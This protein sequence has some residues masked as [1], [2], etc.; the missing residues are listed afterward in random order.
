MLLEEYD[1]FAADDDDIGNVDTVKIRI[2][3]KDDIPC[4]STYHSIPRP[5]HQELKH[6]IED[7]LNRKWI[8][9]SHSEYSSSVVAVEKKDG[10]LRLCCD[11]RKLSAKTVPDR[12]PLHFI[13][14]II[15]SLGTNHYFS[16]LD[17]QHITSY[18]EKQKRR[19]R[20][21][22][23]TP[24]SF[25]SGSG[26]NL[27]LRMLQPAFSAS[28]SPVWES[29]EMILLYHIWMTCWSFQRVFM[30]T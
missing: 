2:K 8:T 7:L 21:A 27:A 23:L 28:W 3:V 4:Q 19:K 24:W 30:I 15:V 26:S 12:H 14:D 18:K 9:S 20:T 25:M 5:L 17:Q 6:Y 22:F 29:A 11:Y 10:S 13:H 1:V 16:L